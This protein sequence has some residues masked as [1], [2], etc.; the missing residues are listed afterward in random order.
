MKLKVKYL[1]LAAQICW[2]IG[3]AIGIVNVL[4]YESET[5]PILMW[6]FF[7]VSLALVVVA[8][9]VRELRRRKAQSAANTT[10]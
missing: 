10:V 8:L 2:F 6:V 1:F 4:L 3:A 7:G 9:I 5:Y